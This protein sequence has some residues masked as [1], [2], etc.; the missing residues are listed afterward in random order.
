MGAIAYQITSHTIVYSIV[1][2]V[3]DQR[4]HQ[5][6]ASLAFVWAIDREYIINIVTGDLMV[7]LSVSIKIEWGELKCLSYLYTWTKS[8][9]DMGKWLLRINE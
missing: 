3:A 4:K 8:T 1:Y 2:S 5:S 6:S 9:F 7:Y